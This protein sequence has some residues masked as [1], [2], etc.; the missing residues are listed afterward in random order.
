VYCL[1]VTIKTVALKGI[2]VVYPIFGKSIEGMPKVVERSR[3]S[4]R[5]EET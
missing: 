1:I 3:K 4:K 2:E 5:K